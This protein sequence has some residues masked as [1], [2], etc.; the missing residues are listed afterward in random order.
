[1]NGFKL[2]TVLLSF[3]Q[4]VGPLFT[5]VILHHL[6]SKNTN[7]CTMY[8]DCKLIMIYLII[9]ISN[10]QTKLIKMQ[11][12]PCLF[13]AVKC[14]WFMQS[15]LTYPFQIPRSRTTGEEMSSVGIIVKF[16]VLKGVEWELRFACFWTRKMGFRSPGLGLCH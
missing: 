5:H 10:S 11:R 8:N 12:S 13:E 3:Y 4:Y 15:L 9:I 7:L 6:Y 1:M 16:R 14:R 2:Q